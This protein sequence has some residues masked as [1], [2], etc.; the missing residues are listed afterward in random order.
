MQK[1][2]RTPD[3]MCSIRNKRT[4]CTVLSDG[5]TSELLR[6]QNIVWQKKLLHN[7]AKGNSLQLEKLFYLI[8]II[9]IMLLQNKQTFNL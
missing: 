3:L 9:I 8:E 2:L 5:K 1:S 6:Q 4:L 7:S